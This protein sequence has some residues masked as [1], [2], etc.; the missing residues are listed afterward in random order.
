MVPIQQAFQ[1][2]IEFLRQAY[3]EET[4]PAA[5]IEE[6]EV[7]EDKQYWYLTV[8]FN[9]MPG[10]PTTGLEA[11]VGRGLNPRR[12]FK[13]FKLESHTGEVVAMNIAQ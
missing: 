13:R 10:P 11:L 5:T 6:A 8:A 2:S 12:T 9:R 7:S 1:S 4:D 3:P